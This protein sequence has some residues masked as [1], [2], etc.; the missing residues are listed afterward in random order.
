MFN[1]LP[2]KFESFR[3]LLPCPL[4]SLTLM[5]DNLFHSK[6]F[7]VPEFPLTTAWQRLGALIDLGLRGLQ[8]P[9]D[10]SPI[11]IMSSVKLHDSFLG[12]LGP[13]ANRVLVIPSHSPGTAGSVWRS[14]GGTWINLEKNSSSKIN[15]YLDLL[16]YW[17]FDLPLLFFI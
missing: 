12:H 16:D 8:E 4:E 9:G 5:E 11:M 3:M 2:L 17:T 15:D 1:L 14:S 10:P 7:Q 6:L 13:L